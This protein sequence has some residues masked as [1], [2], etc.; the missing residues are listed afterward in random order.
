MRGYI[1]YAPQVQF[2]AT[3]IFVIDGLPL[4]GGDKAAGKAVELARKAIP[5]ALD[6]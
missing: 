6:P 2:Y 1:F 3:A 4:R 5:A